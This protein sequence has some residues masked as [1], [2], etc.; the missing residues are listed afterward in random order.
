[1]PDRIF[2]LEAAQKAYS[3]GKLRD[4]LWDYLQSGEAHNPQLAEQ[5]SDQS[6]AKIVLAKL[7]LKLMYRETGPEQNMLW[8]EEL[9]VFETRVKELMEDLALEREMAPLI[10]TDFWDDFHISDGSHRLEALKRYGFDE[11]WTIAVV[12]Q[13]GTWAMIDQ[14]VE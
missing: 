9:K 14:Y 1:M 5:I 10:A 6:D 8:E 11:Y 13:P 12:S 2:T 4:W 7:P 3:D